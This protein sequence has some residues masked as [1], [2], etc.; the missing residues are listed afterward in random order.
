MKIRQAT[1][2]DIPQ[3]V[4]LWLGLSEM[5]A[6]MEPMWETVGNAE[7]IHEA[8][9]KTILIKDNYYIVVAEVENNI[10]GFSTLFLS[11]RP[12]VFLIKRIASI[13][14]TYVKVEFRKKGVARKL[15]EALVSFAKDKGVEMIN[16]SVAVA[17]ESG[18]RFWEEVG[19]KP[20]LN[21]MTMY[22]V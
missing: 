12:E 21:Y 11:D 18:T 22:L 19:F 14:D 9:L 13:H 20:T 15:T 7:E 8:H 4:E 1:I 6:A 16:L 5:H 3:I 10:I 2:D 17:N